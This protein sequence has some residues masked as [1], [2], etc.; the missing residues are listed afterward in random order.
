MVNKKWE[1]VQTIT[2]ETTTNVRKA[3]IHLGIGKHIITRVAFIP[4]NEVDAIR[5]EPRVEAR[6]NADLSKV[7]KGIRGSF[8]FIPENLMTCELEEKQ[9]GFALVCKE[10]L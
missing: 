1:N 4:P 7:D 6:Y 9:Y 10:M 3:G 5:V 2:V 8:T